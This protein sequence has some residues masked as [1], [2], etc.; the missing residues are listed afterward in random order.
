VMKMT[1]TVE[2]SKAARSF[3]VA[4]V[5]FVLLRRCVEYQDPT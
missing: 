1:T 5:W 4:P 3:G 2:S